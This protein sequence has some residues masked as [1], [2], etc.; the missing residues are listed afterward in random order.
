MAA[1]YKAIIDEWKSVYAER[2]DEYV[3]V[4]MRRLDVLLNGIWDG[5]RKG[6]NPALIDRA[7]AIIDRQN[8]LMKL[9]KGGSVARGVVLFE[10]SEGSTEALRSRA[11]EIE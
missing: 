3:Q 1:D 6:E 4:Q 9:G 2:A 8:L 7:L 10:I 5:A 11:P